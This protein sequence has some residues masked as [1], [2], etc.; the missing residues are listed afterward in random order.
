MKKNSKLHIP[1]S[2]EGKEKLK[3]RAGTCEMTLTQYC[4]YILMNTI[5]I[6]QKIKIPN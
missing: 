2:T 4:L 5:P 3:Q 6:K 1:I